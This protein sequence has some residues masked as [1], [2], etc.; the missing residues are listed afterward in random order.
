[1]NRLVCSMVITAPLVGCI[2]GSPSPRPPPSP[3]QVPPPLPSLPSST[4]TSTASSTDPTTWPLA[5]QPFVDPIAAMERWGRSPQ[6]KSFDYQ[7]EPSSKY[8]EFLRARVAAPS[9]ISLFHLCGVCDPTH[10][11]AAGALQVDRRVLARVCDSRLYDLW[12]D[13]DL[14]AFAR[15]EQLALKSDAEV[16]TFLHADGPSSL[17]EVSAADTTGHRFRVHHGTSGVVDRNVSRML[18]L[19]EQQIPLRWERVDGRG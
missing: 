1:M 16:R 4:S 14:I 9:M 17:V 6:F 2:G 15:A 3:A 19:D 8:L 7:Q 18:I 10:P 12:N 5:D 11:A 13:D